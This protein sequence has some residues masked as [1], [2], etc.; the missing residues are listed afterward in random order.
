[1]AF[2]DVVTYVG[3]NVVLMTGDGAVATAAVWTPAT[4]QVKIA[5]GY[6][7]GPAGN[8][9]G[10][11]V[12]LTQGDGGCGVIASISDD[13]S[14]TPPDGGFVMS[15]TLDCW[16]SSAPTFSPDGAVIASAG[17]EGEYG[18]PILLLTSVGGD[19][20]ARL[21][22]NDVFGQYLQPHAIRWLDNQT[23]VLLA[24]SFDSS[25]TE[26]WDQEWGIWRCDIRPSE[27][28]LAQTI[29]FSPTD[30]YQ[31]ALVDAAD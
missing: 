25:R 10:N 16:A 5:L 1:V 26:Y 4:G 14:V 18:P 15:G 7:S 21:P 23:L 29:G 9:S 11:R 22:I 19:E 13:G 27:C 20:L 30:F 6:S 8:T 12:V 17:T 24:S 2:A 28:D 3:D 31:V